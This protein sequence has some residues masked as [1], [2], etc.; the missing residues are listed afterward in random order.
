MVCTK[1][2]S[3]LGP[4]MEVSIRDGRYNERRTKCRLCN[5]EKFIKDV[6][7]PYIFR[8]LVTQLAACN[9]NLKLT[10]NEM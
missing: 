7:I 1:C 6:D 3:L 10:F 4:T 9:I 2:G 8:Y 5:E